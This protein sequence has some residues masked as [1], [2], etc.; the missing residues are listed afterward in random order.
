MSHSSKIDP[1]PC[2]KATEI[3][4]RYARD[5]CLDISYKGHAKERMKER[6]IIIGDVL[7][8]LK[9]GYVYKDP[10][11]TD[12]E[13]LFRYSMESSTPNSHGR[14]LR[15]VLIP[16]PS[17]ASIKIVTVMWVDERI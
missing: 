6:E 17:R 11:E 8:V 7:Y 5:E 4:R 2:S 9:F 14:A 12:R 13:G 10:K 1:W 3:I 15:V 16:S